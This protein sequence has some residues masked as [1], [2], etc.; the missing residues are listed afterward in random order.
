[1]KLEQVQENIS[2]LEVDQIDQT[3]EDEIVSAVDVNSLPDG[4]VTGSSLIEFNDGMKAKLK[5]SVALSLLAAQRVA[6][7]DSSVKN[8]DQWLEKHNQTL[9]KLSWLVEQDAQLNSEFDSLNVAVHE[10]IIPFL[11]AALGPAA[12][13]GSL[14][15]KALEQLK[16]MDKNSSWITLFDKESQR[17]EVN[18]F[19][20]AVVE[21]VGNQTRLRMAAARFDASYGKTQVLFFKIKKADASFDARNMSFLANSELLEEMNVQLRVKL[22]DH[23]RRFIQEMDIGL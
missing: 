1:M 5:S 9:Q 22:R 20:F 6:T 11:T 2:A 23:A 15:I 19:H 17:F 12:V 10:A 21:E 13:A 18:E 8:P 14:I 4:I 16:S 7:N 3:T